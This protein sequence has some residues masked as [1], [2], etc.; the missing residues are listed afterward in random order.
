M[1]NLGKNSYWKKKI[2]QRLKNIYNRF[3]ILYN[4]WWWIIYISLVSNLL[5]L[6]LILSLL[7]IIHGK[8]IFHEL[9]S[10]ILKKAWECITMYLASWLSRVHSSLSFLIIYLLTFYTMIKAMMLVVLLHLVARVNTKPIV[11]NKD[12]EMKR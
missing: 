6:T 7:K 3:L 12:Y 2:L 4:F 10:E 1:G 11:Q 8:D 5:F 9:S